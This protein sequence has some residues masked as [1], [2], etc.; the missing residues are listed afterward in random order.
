[1]KKWYQKLFKNSISKDDQTSFLPKFLGN[2]AF[3]GEESICDTKNDS[4]LAV[5][6]IKSRITT[7]ELVKFVRESRSN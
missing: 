1:M 4:P 7:Q 5:A 3:T 6:G 2:G